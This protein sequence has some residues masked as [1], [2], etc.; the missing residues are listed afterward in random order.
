MNTEDDTPETPEPAAKKGIIRRLMNVLS[1]DRSPETTEALEHEIQELLEEGEEHGLISSLE[2]KMINSIF[3]FRDTLAVE[4]MTPAAEI[5]SVEASVGLDSLVA[6]VIEEGFT[7]MPVYRGNPDRIIGILHVK[8]L[9]RLCTRSGEGS[10]NLEDCLKPALFISENKPVVELLKDFKKRK[11]HMALVTDEFGTVRGLI[12]LE[13]VIEEIVGEI[14]DEYDTDDDTT[15]EEINNDTV[16]VHARIDVEE[17]DERFGV[18]LPDGPYESIGGLVI[19]SL[20]RLAVTGD[21]VDIGELRF[22]VKSA[23]KRHIKMV[24]ITRLGTEGKKE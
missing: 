17:V 10:F 20:G 13:D 18:S 23:S 1:L 2:E 7:R 19:H 24:E 5:V 15:I 8:D 12:T 4:I 22:I 3:D 11:T 16:L 9:L 14:D 21:T 6:V